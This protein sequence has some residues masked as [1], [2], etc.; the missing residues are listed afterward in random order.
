V[1]TPLDV[2]KKFGR[3]CSIE[4]FQIEKDAPIRQFGGFGFGIGSVVDVGPQSGLENGYNSSTS[5]PLG[6][7]YVLL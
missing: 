7:A 5:T 3:Y 6:Y 1:I 2:R 4:L